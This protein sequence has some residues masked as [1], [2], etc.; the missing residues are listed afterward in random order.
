MGGRI[1]LLEIALR[2]SLEAIS[3]EDAV[4]AFVLSRSPDISLPNDMPP[5]L[6]SKHFSDIVGTPFVSLANLGAASFDT[7]GGVRETL[8]FRYLL[9]A[10]T[11][12]AAAFDACWGLQGLPPVQSRRLA[13][14][15]GADWA[16]LSLLLN[17]FCTGQLGGRHLPF[18]HF[19]GHLSGAMGIK[20]ISP[21]RSSPLSAWRV[22]SV[23]RR[24]IATASR[25]HDVR[26][27]PCHLRALATSVCD[28]PVELSPAYGG[29][30]RTIKDL[31]LDFADTVYTDPR[32]FGLA[33]MLK[34][35]PSAFIKSL[36]T[37]K[38]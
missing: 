5:G 38:E 31:C 12:L 29:S 4:L 15:S 24:Y 7:F 34:N 35:E 21:H 3:V 2:E 26:L 27:I 30:S 17:R 22:R 23:D 14:F 32:D 20:L 1:A 25:A 18:I 10:A 37:F 28:F 36:S 6:S 19:V 13:T 11:I 8:C 9:L 16:R 33:E